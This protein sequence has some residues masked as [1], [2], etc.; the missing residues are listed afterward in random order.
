MRISGK[1]IDRVYISMQART[2]NY[3]MVGNH[4]HLYYEI[5]YKKRKM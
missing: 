4:Y 1:I 2:T 3:K 5:Y